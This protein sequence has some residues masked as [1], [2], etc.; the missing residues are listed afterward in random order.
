MLFSWNVAR[1]ED[2]LLLGT[3][4]WAVQRSPQSPQAATAAFEPPTGPSN[5]GQLHPAEVLKIPVFD[6]NE[7][8]SPSI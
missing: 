2:H 3:N 6:Q 5:F 8:P 4:W 1:G 7:A